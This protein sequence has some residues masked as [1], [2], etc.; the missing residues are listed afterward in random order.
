MSPRRPAARWLVVA[1][2]LAVTYGM[3]S[4]LAAY[5]VFLPV[6]AET[7]GW[8][9]GAISVALSISLLL[10]GPAGFVIG[11][12]ADRHGPRALLVATVFLAGAGF[13]LV[14]TVTALWQLYLYVGVMAGIGTSAFYV[15][16][17]S[18][19]SRWFQ[20]GRGLAL[21]IVLT[22]FNLGYMSGGPVAAALIERV[23]WRAAYPLL[24]AGFCG[25][26]ALASLAVRVPPPGAV[27]DPP[28]VER[29]TAPPGGLGVRQ[30]LA[31]ARLWLLA[32]S[33]VLAGGVFL[34]VSVHIVPWATD[35]GFG[36]EAAAWALTAYGF[37]AVSGRFVFGSAVDRI[38]AHLAMPAGVAI[39]VAA[40]VGI[41][42]GPSQGV[43][44]AL[45]VAFGLGFAGADTVF[46]QAVPDVFGVRSLGAIMGVLALGWR[47]GAAIGP[48]AAGFAHDA[49]GS[50]AIP[51][52]A[53]PLALVVSYL[54]YVAG[55]RPRQ[56]GPS[57]RMRA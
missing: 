40:L 5:G 56:A 41:L 42:L 35:R 52:G 15:L 36:L 23:G 38:G 45:L 9:R 29:A 33:W 53:G 10:G 18:T 57:A 43:L 48:A 24:A 3:S 19:V 51:F 55:A 17:A 47:C 50:Y 27:P 39:Q 31:D 7:F 30:A 8:S 6:L 11:T 21:A 37:G 22:G 12:L 1:A 46:V 20:R 54:L 4:P 16:S 25:L 14:G 34:M 13:A 2:L 26:A 28:P 49:T 44:F 32:S